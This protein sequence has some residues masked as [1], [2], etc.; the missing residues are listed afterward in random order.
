MI[1]DDDS[2][3]LEA[4]NVSPC[5]PSEPGAPKPIRWRISYV[6]P[7]IT[8]Y[9]AIEF[10]SLETT[11]SSVWAQ[12]T[13]K[14]NVEHDRKG[15]IRPDLEHS[16]LIPIRPD[17]GAPLDIEPI[18]VTNNTD[19][20][21]MAIKD[22]PKDVEFVINISSGE[23][24]QEFLIDGCLTVCPRGVCEPNDRTMWTTAGGEPRAII[25]LKDLKT[26]H[27]LYESVGVALGVDWRNM[28]LEIESDALKTYQ[29][30]MNLNVDLEVFWNV[31]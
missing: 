21:G 11:V 1:K 5:Q 9:F 17:S 8:S 13:D 20:V 10:A 7:H 30:V 16:I 29:D 3:S 28:L 4:A 24:D 6:T 14:V 25:P 26:V 2:Y 31:P 15:K 23:L 22:W 19:T 18:S 12:I 27:A